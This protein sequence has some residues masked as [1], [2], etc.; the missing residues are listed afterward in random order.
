MALVLKDVDLYV[1]SRD[2]AGWTNQATVTLESEDKEVT[3]FASNGAKERIGGLVDSTVELGGFADFMPNALNA[4]LDGK[5]GQSFVTVIDPMGSAV[6]G[7][8]AMFEQAVLL[9]FTPLDG[10]VGDV[11]GYSAS[12]AGQS[13][14]VPG[15]V[16]HPLAIRTATGN[17]GSFN[18]KAVGSSQVLSAALLVTDVAGTG[19][20][21]VTVKVQSDDN[22]G[23]TSPTDRIT[24]PAQTAVGATLGTEVPGPITDTYY[25]VN[26]TIT[27]TGPSVTFLVVIGIH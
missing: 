26:Y 20:P 2:L 4:I 25:R 27:G 11:A 21:G 17:G 7:S 14:L 15:V 8:P 1:G 23:M 12:L 6:Q 3:T 19:G 9:D 18:F 10:A 16:L 5:I 24:F 13:P 22:A